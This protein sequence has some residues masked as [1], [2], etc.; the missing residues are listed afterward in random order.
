MQPTQ[1]KSKSYGALGIVAAIIGLAYWH[2]G[3]SKVRPPVNVT[4]AQNT[5]I[6]LRLDQ[7][8]NSRTSV[9]GQHFGGK[10]A[11]PLMVDGHV[12]LPAGT[13]FSGTVMEAIPAGK[14]AGG[15]TLRI[16]LNSFSF[17]GKEHK[18]QAHPLVRTTPGQGKRTITVAGG[19]AAIGAAI[20]ALAQGGKGALLGAAAGAGA[21]ALG[22]A[23]TNHPV[24]VVMPAEAVVTFHLAGPV[25][26]A[27]TPPTPVHHSWFSS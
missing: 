13:E 20:G 3:V 15:A 6:A 8:L 4:L 2:P 26:V 27:L 16:A 9:A 17:Q 5:A 10:L 12:A 7:S 23:A 21:G 24:N 11:Q 19:G 18:I 1:P 14:L 25:T 22:A